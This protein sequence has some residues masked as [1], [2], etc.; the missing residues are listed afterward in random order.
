MNPQGQYLGRIE[1]VMLNSANQIEFALVET[2][3]PNVDMTV[4]PVPWSLL[5]YAWDQSKAGG[6]P[7]AVQTFL[8]SVDKA[9]LDQAPKINRKNRS[10]LGPEWE[11][12]VLAFY[13]LTPGAIRCY[14]HCLNIVGWRSGRRAVRR[15]S[16]VN[17]GVVQA[18]LEYRSTAIPAVTLWAQAGVL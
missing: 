17:P 18:V 6:T 5:S 16:A 1:E 2:S 4:T 15:S 9:K 13:G 7:G 12:R 14:G 8:A 3:H 10:N 11:Q